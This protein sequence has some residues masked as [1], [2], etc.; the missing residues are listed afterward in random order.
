MKKKDLAELEALKQ[1]V[2]AGDNQL[3]RTFDMYLE[4]LD[5]VNGHGRERNEQQAG[6]EANV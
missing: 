4:L 5:K 2:E 1:V 3:R 6:V